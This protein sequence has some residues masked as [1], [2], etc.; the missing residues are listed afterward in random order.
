MTQGALFPLSTA[1]AR[2]NESTNVRFNEI[3][4][5]YRVEKDEDA[6]AHG[7]TKSSDFSN[8]YEMLLADPKVRS[9]RVLVEDVDDL[10]TLKYKRKF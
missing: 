7:V 1:A 6:I 2:E 4:L 3:Y 9:A 10:G 8:V 5:C